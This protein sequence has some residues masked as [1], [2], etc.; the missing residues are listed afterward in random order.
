M[1]YTLTLNPALDC[2][3]ELKNLNF[4][5]INRA[6]EQRFYC[7]GKGINV[8]AVLN[9]LGVQNTA[10]GIAGGFT[11]RELIRLAEADGINCDFVLSECINTRVNVKIRAEKELDINPSGEGVNSG[12]LDALMS[13]LE[14]LHSGDTLV[15]SGSV[16][17]GI[18]N[19]IYADI[20]RRLS[21]RG[22]KFVVDAEGDLLL[23][24]LKY[25]PFLIKPNHHELGTIFN[26]AA[27][28]E[29][30]IL[31]CAKKLKEIGAQNVLVS[32]A[33]KGAILV[34]END[35][36]YVQKA[37][38]GT[39]INSVGCGDSMVAGFIAGCEKGYEYALRLALACG[40]ATAFSPALATADEIQNLLGK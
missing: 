30:E 4:D 37:A 26:T 25:K 36:V 28:S 15:L 38:C 2:V 31:A 7:G 14:R 17:R 3:V 19:D 18:N 6:D 33:E 8:S 39:L 12:D 13:K 23:N 11:G 40:S 29:D 9:R 35:R 27:D 34:D 1:V 32:R 22:I 20:M 24:T 10:L 16:P 21:L 5:N